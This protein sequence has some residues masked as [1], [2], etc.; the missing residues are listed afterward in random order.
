MNDLDV[1]CRNDTPFKY[2]TVSKERDNDNSDLIG[3][4][5]VVFF[6]FN[7]VVTSNRANK[8]TVLLLSNILTLNRWHSDSSWCS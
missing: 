8:L 5:V 7:F 4:G 2:V 6:P 3:E 1:K